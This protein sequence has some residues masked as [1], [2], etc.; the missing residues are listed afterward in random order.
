MPSDRVIG[1]YRRWYA[2]LLRLYPR[3]F[4]QRFAE[5]MAQT[6][7]DLC[8]ERTDVNRGLLGVAIRMFAETS[9]G[10]IRENLAHMTMQTKNYLRWVLVTAVVLLIPFLAMTFNWSIPDPGSGADGVNWGPM[11]FAIV[12][13]LVLGAGL[14]YDYASARGGNVAHRAALGIAVAAGLFLIWVNL[15]VGMIDVAPANLMYALVLFVAL[16]GAAIGR[17]EPREASVAMFATAGAQ[18]LV[19]VIALVAALGPTLLADAF[20]VA[21]WVASALLFRQAGVAS[22]PAR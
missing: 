20:F 10:I 3:P 1:R 6:F 2:R 7:A 12:G 21:A 16:V 13:V 19:A 15:A 5:P 8:R 17:F 11:D 9:V 4:R 18:A 22:A 14:L